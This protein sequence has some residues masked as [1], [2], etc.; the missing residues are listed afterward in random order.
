MV[1]IIRTYQLCSIDQYVDG[2]LA[3]LL[4]CLCLGNGSDRQSAL[5]LFGEPLT[6]VYGLNDVSFR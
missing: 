5:K 6:A 1:N 2:I 4:K 3:L